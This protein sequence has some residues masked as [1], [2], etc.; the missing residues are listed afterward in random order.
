MTIFDYNIRS[1]FIWQGCVYSI[2]IGGHSEKLASLLSA[3][4]GLVD[5]LFQS[6]MWM[7]MLIMTLT[8]F[9]QSPWMVNKFIFI[10]IQ[11]TTIFSIDAMLSNQGTGAHTRTENKQIRV[12]CMNW[13]GS[14][15]YTFDDD[16][17]HTLYTHLHFTSNRYFFLSLIIHL[18]LV[19]ILF[20]FFS[21]FLYD[22][23]IKCKQIERKLA[24]HM[25]CHR[26]YYGFESLQ[27]GLKI[28]PSGD[29]QTLYDI[30]LFNQRST[31]KKKN[32]FLPYDS[33]S[34]WV[35][36]LVLDFDINQM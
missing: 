1:N 33:M 27:C 3:W 28:K 11:I 30:L 21:R 8:T 24:R 32:R 20:Y 29:S 36:V 12:L 13:R 25:E 17:D 10:E 9:N 18:V 26:N 16:D 6:Q 23:W 22:T 14:F 19:S 35:V 34:N 15:M 4:F 7:L 2:T 31:Q 5:K